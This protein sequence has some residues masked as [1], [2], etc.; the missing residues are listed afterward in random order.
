MRAD[1]P[2]RPDVRPVHDA[3]DRALLDELRKWTI[4][5]PE[6]MRLALVRA[7]T[8]GLQQAGLLK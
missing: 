4:D 8:K 1:L 3:L 7:G 5:I 2:R 6:E